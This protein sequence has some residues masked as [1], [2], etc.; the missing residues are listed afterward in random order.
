MPYFCP[1]HVESW[2]HM[3][4]KRL[5]ERMNGIQSSL[6]RER[7][8][9]DCKSA[10]RFRC[11]LILKVIQNNFFLLLDSHANF[12]CVSKHVFPQLAIQGI[13]LIRSR[14]LSASG[15]IANG[16]YVPQVGSNIGHRVGNEPGPDS[17]AGDGLRARTGHAG[18]CGPHPLPA[19]ALEGAR[20][21]PWSPDPVPTPLPV[22]GHLPL[23]NLLPCLHFQSRKIDLPV[24]TW[25]CTL[26]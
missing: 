24:F 25:P 22:Q 18:N 13:R 1:K 17:G 9:L 7:T 11:W 12:R 15:Q 6:Q 10:R 2:N 19:Q 16:R 20:P 21:H 14:V 4:T 23:P 26:L 5:S 3:Q 8:V